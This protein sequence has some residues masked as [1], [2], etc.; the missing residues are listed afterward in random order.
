MLICFPFLV[1]QC[2]QYTNWNYK[3][4]LTLHFWGKAD[5]VM[6]IYY[7]FYRL[8][9]Q[10]VKFQGFLS[11]YSWTH[12]MCYVWNEAETIQRFCRMLG[13]NEFLPCLV[14]DLF[15]FLKIVLSFVGDTIML[16]G[17]SWTFFFSFLGLYLK[18]IEVPR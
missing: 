10:F 8:W 7:P 1:C 2:G 12:L 18:H 17:K 6:M 4:K 9:I 11:L 15:L 3:V 14:L 16:L 13:H 5:L